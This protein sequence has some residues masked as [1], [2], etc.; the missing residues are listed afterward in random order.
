[1]LQASVLLPSDIRCRLHE[2]NYAQLGEPAA[3]TASM[4]TEGDRP[5]NAPVAL[6]PTERGAFCRWMGAEIG[7]DK[8]LLV[9]L[10]FMAEETLSS[11]AQKKMWDRTCQAIVEKHDADGLNQLST[12]S[13]EESAFVSRLGGE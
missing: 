2:S 8:T 5:R 4:R 9:M 12:S 11:E 1:M 10:D 7:H 13:K 6:S 3:A